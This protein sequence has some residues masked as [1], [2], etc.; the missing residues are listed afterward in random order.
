MDIQKIIAR[1]NENVRLLSDDTISE[2]DHDILLNDLRQLYS[3]VKAISPVKSW[4]DKY[5]GPA[6]LP[7]IR[8]AREKIVIGHAEDTPAAAEKSTAINEEPAI[9]KPLFADT[10]IADAADALDVIEQADPVQAPAPVTIAE[11]EKTDKPAS[12]NEVFA[13]EE[14]SLNSR[15]SSGSSKPALNDKH[16]GGKDLKSMIDFNKQYILTNE[17]FKGDSNAFQTAISRI[18]NAPN[19]EAAFEYIKTDLMP[20]YKWNGEMQSARLFDKLVRQKFGV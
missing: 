1:I 7:S 2:I 9:E 5:E 11:K 17:L 6:K 16:L 8:S 3:L 10:K 19:I 14:R 20:V 13:G 15:L 18:N 12:L 4:D